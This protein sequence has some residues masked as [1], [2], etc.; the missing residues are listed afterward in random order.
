L[1]TKIILSN[2]FRMSIRKGYYFS[3]SS[4]VGREQRF[5]VYNLGPMPNDKGGAFPVKDARDLSI[6]DE[7]CFVEAPPVRT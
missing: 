5:R 7:M 3:A 6:K 1:K 4:R 2:D